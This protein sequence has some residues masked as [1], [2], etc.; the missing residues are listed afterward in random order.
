MRRDR[1]GPESGKSAIHRRTADERPFYRVS[2]PQLSNPYHRPAAKEFQRIC[3]ETGFGAPLFHCTN[4]G[5]IPKLPHIL[6]QSLSFGLLKGRL[7]SDHLAMAV[8][9]VSVQ[10]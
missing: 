7:F 8:R 1:D 10:I 3:S 9:K 6:W 2:R 4:S 5:G